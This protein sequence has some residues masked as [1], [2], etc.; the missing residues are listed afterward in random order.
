MP[1]LDID[2]FD[3]FLFF[4]FVALLFG[5][6]DEE[7]ETFVI[8]MSTDLFLA[9]FYLESSKFINAQAELLNRIITK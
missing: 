4:A 8:E 5:L 9:H 2:L 1:Q 6:G 3:D 7:G